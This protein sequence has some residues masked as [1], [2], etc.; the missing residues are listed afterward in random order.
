[1]ELSIYAQEGG[2]H[3]FVG[4]ECPPG[5]VVM[6][7]ER[8]G[9]LY[10]ADAEGEWHAP[11][12]VV[13]AVVSRFQ[14]RQALRLSTIED[15]RI[16]INDTSGPSPAKRDLLAV[17]EDLLAAPTTPAY[18]REAWNDIQQ[19]ERDSPMLLA[20]ADELGLTAANLDDLFILAAT[21]RA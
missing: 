5:W 14:G 4:G 2:S 6:K 17:V 1:M 19:F 11:P 15:G 13:P 7:G 18:Y 8:P 9:P 21:L 16:V 3:I 20:I 12:A 10:I